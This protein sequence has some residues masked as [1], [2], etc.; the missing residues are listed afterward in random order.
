M[1]DIFLRVI[2]VSDPIQGKSG[3]SYVVAE[4]AHVENRVGGPKRKSIGGSR[5]A[6]AKAVLWLPGTEF[7]IPG[8]TR[9]VKPANMYPVE[10]LEVGD[11]IDGCLV[12]VAV[13]PQRPYT[14]VAE[15]GATIVQHEVKVAVMAT[16]D[17]MLFRAMLAEAIAAKG[18]IPADEELRRS[19]SRI[20]AAMK[21]DGQQTPETPE[22]P[23]VVLQDP[24][25]SGD[26]Q[27]DGDTPF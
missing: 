16:P 14:W 9:T 20:P 19:T 27:G 8:T 10:G 5:V 25:E 17:H 4:F 12:M 21:V 13:D 2:S 1:K 23:E 24:Y 15:D 11:E 3:Q 6:T 22:T 7:P 18:F 26:G